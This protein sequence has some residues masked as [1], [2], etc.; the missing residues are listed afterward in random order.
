MKLQVSGPVQHFVTNFFYNEELFASCKT[1]KLGDHLS[2]TTTLYICSYLPYLEDMS[3][4]CDLRKYHDV[5]TRNP[6]NMDS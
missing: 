3:T 1:S 4:I 5:V 6:V 2:V